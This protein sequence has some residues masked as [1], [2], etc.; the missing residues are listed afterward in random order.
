M[1][2]QREEPSSYKRRSIRQGARNRSYRLIREIPP[3]YLIYI[4]TS[5]IDVIMDGEEYLPVDR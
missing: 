2:S 1:N 4:Y 3:P 5:R